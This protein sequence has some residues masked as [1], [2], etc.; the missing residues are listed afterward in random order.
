MGSLI[1]ASAMRGYP[2]LVRELGGDPAVFLARFDI[3][4]GAERQQ[5]TFISFAS[6]TR[7][8]EA[9]AEE[10]ACPDFGLRLSGRQG[11]EILGPIAVIARNA[12]TVLGGVEAIGRF[13]Y[14]HSPALKLTAR[15]RA[16]GGLEFTYEMTEPGVPY[17]QGYELSMGIAVRIIHLLGGPQ[18]GFEAVS[19][20]HPQQG[21]GRRLPR[22]A[23][24]PGALRAAVVRVRAVV[25]DGRPAH[26]ERGPGDPAHRHQIP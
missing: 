9:T 25:A 6:L 2:E 16:E 1:R 18:A 15:P 17:I 10:L 24:L 11:L 8:L 13:L 26:R 20:L 7:M 21:S 4:A 22:R 14:I 23:G 12:S 19:F 3:P 5:D